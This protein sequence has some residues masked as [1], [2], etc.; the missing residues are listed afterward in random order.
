M[1]RLALVRR[2][3]C[4][5]WQHDW[6]VRRVSPPLWDISARGILKTCRNCPK[7]VAK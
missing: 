6:D 2:K 3:H 7:V 1:R 4:W 5:P